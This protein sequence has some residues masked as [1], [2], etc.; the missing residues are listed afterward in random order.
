MNQSVSTKTDRPF[1]RLP[2]TIRQPMHQEEE[3]SVFA[4]QQ[5]ALIDVRGSGKSD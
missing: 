2:I 3:G 5:S 1:V 4:L